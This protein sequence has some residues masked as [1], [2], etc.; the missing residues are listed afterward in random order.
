M[1]SLSRLVMFALLS[2]LALLTFVFPREQLALNWTT[3]WSISAG[4]GLLATV[5]SVA[6]ARRR[7]AAQSRRTAE[8]RSQRAEAAQ[9]AAELR[10]GELAAAYKLL[11]TQCDQ[12]QMLIA[13][14][15]ALETPVVP[16]AEGLL[17]API[18]GYLD[19]RRADA[20]MDR[21]LQEVNKTRANLVLLDIAGV[22]RF[23]IA[24]GQ[25]LL[26][27]LHAIQLL[28]CEVTLSGIS[29][30]FAMAFTYLG[31]NLDTIRTVRSPQQALTSYLAQHNAIVPVV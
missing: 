20:L 7:S 11:Q 17:L 28:G 15:R 27:T 24:V 2:L 5:G 18:V 31:I 14:L 29:A 21:L 9:A 13:S 19:A 6:L 30:D 4:F 26:D 3:A 12:Q 1:L 25:L 16:L 23:D 8:E 22:T 10:A